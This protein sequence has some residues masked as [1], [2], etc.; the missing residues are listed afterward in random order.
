MC[1]YV[2]YQDGEFM[3]PVQAILPK[4][5]VSVPSTLDFQMCAA[6]DTATLTFNVVN[7]G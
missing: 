3:V 6:H 7:T 5:M 4:T 1:A 2:L